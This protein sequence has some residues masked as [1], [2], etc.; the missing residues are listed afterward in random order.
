MEFGSETQVDQ[1]SLF[2]ERKKDQSQS[3]NILNNSF[4]LQIIN[5]M[6][7]AFLN[8]AEKRALLWKQQQKNI[9]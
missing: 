1:M 7:F 5:S 9:N 2:K 4:F 3:F 8:V 6:C